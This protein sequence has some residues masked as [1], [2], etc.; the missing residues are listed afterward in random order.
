M[1]E[2]F[3][4]NKNGETKMVKG[5]PCVE[6]DPDDFMTSYISAKIRQPPI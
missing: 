6:L 3:G 2:S 1:Q 5:K 4:S